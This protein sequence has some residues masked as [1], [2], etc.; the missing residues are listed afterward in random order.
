MAVVRMLLALALTH[1]TTAI[2]TVL[3]HPLGIRVAK[4]LHSTT[5]KT[6]LN[7]FSII[8]NALGGWPDVY[9]HGMS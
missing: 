4:L 2:L 1:R 5:H 7:I 9:F 3:L 6:E 8:P